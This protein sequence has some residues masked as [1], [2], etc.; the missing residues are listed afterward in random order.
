MDVV[1]AIHTRRSIRKYRADPVPVEIIEEVIWAAVQAP[2]PPVSGDAPWAISVVE[3]VDRLSRYGERAMRFARDH[4]QAKW[5]QM[6]GFKVF[7]DAPVLILIS[8]QEGNSETPFD[9][10]RAGQNLLLAAHA[11]GLGSCWL[12][13]P[14]PWLTSEGVSQELGLPKGYDVVVAI[15]LGFPAETPAGHPRSRQGRSGGVGNNL[16]SLIRNHPVTTLEPHPAGLSGLF[17]HATTLKP[18][19]LDRETLVLFR[20]QN[21]STGCFIAL[22]PC[23][24]ATV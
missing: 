9:C 22:R 3:G 14:I 23:S 5:P 17:C 16:E 15:V 20:S 8:A 18:P 19:E 11:K 4:T 1:T 13:S 24:P 2:L 10:C 7:W 12:G 21:F 6:P